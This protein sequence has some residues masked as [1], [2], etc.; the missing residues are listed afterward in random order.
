MR[1]KST[2]VGFVEVVANEADGAYTV[3]GW[4]AAPSINVVLAHGRHP[5]TPLVEFDVVPDRPR[6]D[7]PSLVAPGFVV[8]IG[9]ALLNLLPAGTEIQVSAGG[10][11]LSVLAG[12]QTVLAGRSESPAQ[13]LS[14]LGRG[15]CWNA[16]TGNLHL[17]IAAWTDERR[18]ATLDLLVDVVEESH[19]LLTPTYGTLLGIARSGA[20]IPHDNDVDAASFIPADSIEE[21]ADR[22]AAVIRN[23]AS[24]TNARVTFADDLFHVLLRREDA[25]I[26]CWPIWVR[27][28]GTFVDTHAVGRLADLSL[29]DSVLE[30]RHVPILRE[31]TSFLAHCYGPNFLTPNPS[32]QPERLWDADDRYREAIAFRTLTNEALARRVTLME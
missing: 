18:S 11:P 29:I 16:K 22:W 31:T 20:L 26:D 21:L 2:A 13:L 25:L 10:T 14:A 5:K 3:A 4:T 6:I 30:G 8:R 12:V 15:M 27:R 9:A 1:K 24:R 23:V 19:Q 17:P 32:W 7:L 28:D